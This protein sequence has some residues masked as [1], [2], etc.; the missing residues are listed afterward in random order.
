MLL[1]GDNVTRIEFDFIYKDIDELRSI[2]DD[3]LRGRFLSSIGS[4]GFMLTNLCV[5]MSP[6]SFP[7]LVIQVCFKLYIVDFFSWKI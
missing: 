4:E 6:S 1:L 3:A 5:G 7:E 2:I